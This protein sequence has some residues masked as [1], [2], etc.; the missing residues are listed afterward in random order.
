MPFLIRTGTGLPLEA[1]T[2]WITAERRALGM[3]P[4]TLFN[5][6]RSLMFLYLWA[7]LRGVDIE[8]RLRDGVFLSLAEIID[9]VG[10]C[11]RYL[12][13][14]LPELGHLR[15]NVVSLASRKKGPKEHSVQ[16]GEKRNRLSVIRT[17]IDFTSADHLSQLQQW[18]TRWSVFDKV[19]RE[20]LD[21]MGKY[22][23]AIR[24]PNRD[25]IGQ[26]E[27]LNSE[28]VKR[29]LAI[30]EPDHPENPFRPEVRFRNYLIVR[31]LIE[32]GIRRG[33]L[34]GLYVVDLTL[35]GSK[36]TVTIHRRPDDKH[37][38]RRVKPAAKTAARVLPLS[39]RATELLHEW[40]V[41][42][43]SKLPL[44][45][46]NPFLIVTV[47]DGKPMS[48]S[49][50]NKIFQALRRRV[51]GLPDELGPH[52]LRH[53]WNDAFSEQVDRK[54]TVSQEEEIKWR[55]RLMG[56]R[57]EATARHYLRRTT[58]RRSN[59]FLAEIQEGLDIR[60]GDEEVDT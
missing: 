47:P 1:P 18:P 13:D 32:L 4:N 6:L 53:S 23:G 54:G 27:G 36:G 52:L 38:S 26:R 49:N 24:A 45:K 19:R 25:D 17:F 58:R 35:S 21:R 3:Q 20:C 8:E 22:I 7:D 12:A 43:R 46:R 42:Y 16:S 33:E 60:M 30:V 9:L 39:G 28:M 34:L 31:L 55:M 37:D 41:E 5:E 11:G 40:V 10:F 50:I 59:E 56:W 44:S 48:L 57:N 15:S 51:P 14:I 2:Y 29:V